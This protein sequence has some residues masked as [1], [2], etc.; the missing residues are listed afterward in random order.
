[1]C[2]CVCVYTHTFTSVGLSLAGPASL[3]SSRYGWQFPWGRPTFLSLGP[4]KILHRGF[5]VTGQ[6]LPVSVL[7]LQLP[8]PTLLIPCSWPLFGT[9]W[10]ITSHA[11]SCCLVLRCFP[12]QA[13]PQ[14]FRNQRVGSQAVQGSH[15]PPHGDY[16]E[17]G[18]PPCLLEQTR[19]HAYQCS[20]APT[21]ST[22]SRGAAGQP[23]MK[24]WDTP[25]GVPPCVFLTWPHFTLTAPRWR[26]PEEHRGGSGSTHGSSTKHLWM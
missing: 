10:S 21:H 17:Q 4:G 19:L 7:A 18:Q 1:V 26:R 12:N 24:V 9:S 6:E 23:T 5:L 20:T 8:H 13:L 11:P 14:W 2:V 15:G 22:K 16:K 3:C 25:E